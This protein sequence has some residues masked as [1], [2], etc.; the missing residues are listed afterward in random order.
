MSVNMEKLPEADLSQNPNVLDRL[1]NRIG[2]L[3]TLRLLLLLFAV[4]SAIHV[5]Y[6][7]QP[8]AGFHQW[9]QTQTLAVARNFYEEGGSIL[10][11]RV[12][13]RGQ[14]SG[15]TGM[16]FPIV[17]YVIALNYSLFGYGYVVQ[18]TTILVFS[19]IAL[20]GCFLFVSRL[21]RSRVL[22]F[23]ASFLLIFSPLFYYYSATALPDVPALSFLFL[24]LGLWQVW[25]EKNASSWLVLSLVSLMLASLVKIYCLVAVPYYLYESVRCQRSLRSSYTNVLGLGVVLSVIT[26]WYF[27][28]RYL[29]DLHHNHDFS[30]AVP[31]PYEFSLVPLALKKVF[32]QWLPELYINH[33]EFILLCAGL[34]VLFSSLHRDSRRFRL[35]YFFPL[36][37]YL[38]FQLP[39]L[40]NHDYYMMP[41]LPL[42]ILVAV[43]GFDHLV[44]ISRN[45]LWL[46]G[47]VFA[48]LVAIPI[49]GSARALPRFERSI[50]GDDLMEIEEHLD[51][52]IPD[53]SALVIAASDRSP[54]TY[55]YFMHRK[56]WPATEVISGEQFR[57]M[58][59]QGARYLVSDNRELERR[60]E[61]S[62]H[63]DSVSSLGA[64]NI[65]YLRELEPSHD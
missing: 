45:R 48:L 9:R 19:L 4:Q 10:E 49:V 5:G 15:I 57:I 65:F 43:I 25:R 28:A 37:L 20:S 46:R 34:F 29:S 18:R 32:I 64:F 3:S 59:N 23:V 54:S 42:L 63:L 44:K 27:Y 6:L 26:S 22:G 16:E 61:I 31:F 53:R 50:I 2:A 33:A 1:L 7:N 51:R 58:I 62:R 36:F 60:P 11:P 55:L 17:N 21:L 40:T 39:T 12:D 30:L 38:I 35:L 52:T 14:Y 47:V 56:G 13:S 24:S 8:P 41:S